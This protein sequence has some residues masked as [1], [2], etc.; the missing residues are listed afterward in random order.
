[1]SHFL[2]MSKRIFISHAKEDA[3]LAKLI[4]ADLESRG[5]RCW[6][7]SRNITPAATWGQA[8]VKGISDSRLMVL[9]LTQHAVESIHVPREMELAMEAKI[10]VIPLQVESVRLDGAL[11]YY[12]S[13]SHLLDATELDRQATLEAIAGTAESLAPELF[14]QEPGSHLS[15]SRSDPPPPEEPEPPAPAGY[16]MAWVTLRPAVVRNLLVVSVALSSFVTAMTLWLGPW[17]GREPAGEANGKADSSVVAGGPASVDSTAGSDSAPVTV[18]DTVQGKD[19]EAAGRALARS[20]SRVRPLRIG[21]SI[22]SL[23][24]AMGSLGVFAVDRRGVRYLVTSRYVIA[25][26]SYREGVPVFQ[27]SLSDGG[28]YPQD[29]VATLAKSFPLRDS[30]SAAHLIVAARLDEVEIDPTVPRIGT[31]SAEVLPADSSLLGKTVGMYGYGSGLNTATVT[32]VGVAIPQPSPADSTRRITVTGAL[33]TRNMSG[34][35]DGGAVVFDRGNRAIG[36]VLGGSRETTII[37][38]LKPFLDHFGLRLLT[39]AGQ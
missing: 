14:E 34:S 31:L 24:N 9:V 30:I 28:L 23:T 27:P 32:M 35:G 16:T 25:V 37:A 8:I 26:E 22:G 29:A 17:G 18:A 15:R 20:R 21:A 39:T 38:P 33:A 11:K 7:A 6:I 3:T 19:D 2:S 5:A 1:M 13:T 4:V 36:I 12:L 10:P